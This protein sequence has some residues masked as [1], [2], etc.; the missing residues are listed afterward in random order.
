MIFY[1]AWLARSGV[2]YRPLLPRGRRLRRVGSG[3]SITGRLWS[4]LQG[5]NISQVGVVCE[6]FGVNYMKVG[7]KI[8]WRQA[9]GL[10]NSRRFAGM[11]C[12]C[13]R[14]SS[15][16]IARPKSQ[17]A[18]LQEPGQVRLLTRLAERK[19]SGADLDIAVLGC[20]KGAEV[21]SIIGALR[22]ARPDLNVKVCR[23]DISAD[24]RI[25]EG[26]DV[27]AQRL[28]PSDGAR[29]GQ[30]CRSSSA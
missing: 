3:A 21:Y 5:A 6:S 17:Y 10:G 24:P 23:I 1:R 2:L 4:R 26:G 30:G 25:R 13:T 8:W 12:T 9:I 20:S 22:Q 18:V 11:E 28:G 27:L 19:E 16:R 15:R 14:S 7:R 29:S